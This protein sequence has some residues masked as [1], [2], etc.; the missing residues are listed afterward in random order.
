M[1]FKKHFFR[2][3]I[4]FLQNKV[5]EYSNDFKSESNDNLCMIHKIENKW[6]E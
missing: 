3:N 6:L 5:R 2:R 1:T 4:S